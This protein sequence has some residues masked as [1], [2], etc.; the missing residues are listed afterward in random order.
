MLETTD[1]LDI[2]Q[3]RCRQGWLVNYDNQAFYDLTLEFY[4]QF[5]QIPHPAKILLVEANPDSFLAAFLA[6]VSARHW[7]FLGTCQWGDQEWNQVLSLVQ[8]D[9]IWGYSLQTFPEQ[10]SPLP[11]SL[12]ASPIM[13]PT[14]GT[15]G[16]IRFAIHS[17]KTLQASVQGF[18]SYFN[19]HSVN[20]F[21]VLPLYHVSGLMQFLRSFLTGGRFYISPYQS[22]KVSPPEL[23]NFQNYFISLVP[24]QLQ[25]LLDFYPQWLAGFQTV[26]LGGAPAETSL[27]EKARKFAINL[28][29]TYGM[30]ETASQIATLKSGDFLQGNNTVSYTHLTLPTKRIV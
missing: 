4:Q 30:T 14:G 25:F 28:S 23:G 24:T 10:I 29:P 20:S 17:W 3:Q 9:L 27:L 19:L 7:L 2:L 21:C 5:S 18:Q 11:Y 15:S 16:K 6:G 13:I 1:I 12:P 8:P 22:L 26:L